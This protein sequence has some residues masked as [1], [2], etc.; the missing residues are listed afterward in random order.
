MRHCGNRANVMVPHFSAVEE[1]GET[2]VHSL[3]FSVYTWKARGIKN[4]GTEAD[5]PFGL[6]NQ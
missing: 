4:H 5:L 3:R 2:A 6:Q 1:E